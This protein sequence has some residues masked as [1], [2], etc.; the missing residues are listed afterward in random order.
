MPTGAGEVPFASAL[1]NGP[2]GPDLSG[3][4]THCYYG[5]PTAMADVHAME[6][7]LEEIE[8]ECATGELNFPVPELEIASLR[9]WATGV[10]LWNLALDP[11]GGPVQPPNYGCLGCRGIVTHRSGTLR[12]SGS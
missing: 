1:L 7:R 9:E 2:A 10:E 3:I 6:P 4:A 12:R 11:R 8:S 5:A